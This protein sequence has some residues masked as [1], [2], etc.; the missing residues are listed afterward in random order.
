MRGRD[1]SLFLLD[2][3]Q[4]LQGPPLE[5]V[6]V[7]RVS[8]QNS[9]LNWLLEE[10]EPSVR[11]HTLTQLMGLEEN[12][13]LVEQARQNIGGFGWANTILS[14]QK[15]GTYWYSKASC[16]APKW[17]S[18]VWQLMVL[19]DLGMTAEDWRMRNC[20]EHFF[21]LHNVESGGF[22]VAARNPN[23]FEPHVCMT[24]NMVRTLA[25]M[26]YQRDDRVLKAMDWLIGQQLEDGGWNCSAKEGGK[27]GS[28]HA[29]VE[30]LWGLSEMNKSNSREDWKVSAKKGSEFL[31]R[32]RIYKSDR[33]DSVI[34]L[35]FLKLHYPIHYRYD[36]LHALRVLTE[37]GVADV[38]RMKDAVDFLLGK[39]LAD[40]AWPLEAVYRGWR[41]PYAFHGGTRTYRPEELE[42]ITQGWGYEHTQQL[43]EAGKPSKW[44]TLQALL[45]LKRLGVLGS[46]SAAS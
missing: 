19:A 22:A 20:V 11:Y 3:N 33:D 1:P 34:L 25:K 27:H 21:G 6:Q 30:P 35:D 40:G 45:V 23:L 4:R 14:R 9:L 41:L 42:L 8:V 39:R 12:D 26:G 37:M 32:H 7:S 13:K 36:I 31:L 18:S 29:T 44:I 15:E 28:F 5:E 38:P 17:S 10:K 16:Y 24:G 2:N 43:E 46:V